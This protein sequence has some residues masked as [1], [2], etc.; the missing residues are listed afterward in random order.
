[1]IMYISK[2][3]LKKVVK[4]ILENSEWLSNEDEALSEALEMLK[5]GELEDKPLTEEERKSLIRYI[6]DIK[7][8]DQ[9]DI[10]TNIFTLS[11]TYS[12]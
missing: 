12:H 8:L 10:D 3:S 6:S 11:S 2:K 9:R 5:N 4:Y 7:F 1:M